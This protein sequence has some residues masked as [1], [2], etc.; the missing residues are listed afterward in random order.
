MSFGIVAS[1]AV[2]MGL[3]VAPAQAGTIAG[4]FDGNSILTPTSTPGVFIQNFTGDGDDTTFGPFTASSQSTIDFSNRPHIAVSNVMLLETFAN[5]T[6]FGTGSGSGTANG[7]GTA[8]FTSDFIITG[9][10]GLFAG[11]TGKVTI[12]GTISQ[13]GPTTEGIN[14]SFTGSLNAPEPSTLILTTTCL[15]GFGLRRIRV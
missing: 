10:T 7:Q 9:G 1:F 3:L 2:A 4:T 8:L 15:V 13:T 6:L 11:N 14:A 12:T 5:G